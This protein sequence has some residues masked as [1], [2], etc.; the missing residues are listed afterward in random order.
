VKE[1]TRK[2]PIV[3]ARQVIMYLSVNF[4][5]GSYETI[6]EKLGGLDHSTVSHAVNVIKNYIDTD[7]VKKGKIEYYETLISKV[8]PM[9]KRVD[10]INDIV[11][12]LEKHIS[13]LEQRCINMSL[14]VNHLNGNN[15]DKA[16][17]AA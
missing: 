7:K 12:T 1:E 8:I 4:K 17:N 15:K 3:F 10:D 13:K 2:G 14:L 6:A 11:A 5:A 16:E 9:M